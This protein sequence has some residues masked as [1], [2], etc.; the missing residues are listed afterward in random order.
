MLETLEKQKKIVG[1][2][3]SCVIELP[4]EFISANN[5]P[6]QSFVRLTVQDDKVESEI[7]VYTDA[8]EKKIQDFITAF[9]GFNEEMKRLGD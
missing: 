8:D 4:A 2:Y 5:L 1:E 7:I 3:N 9:P 6:A